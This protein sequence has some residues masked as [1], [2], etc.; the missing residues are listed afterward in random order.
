MAYKEMLNKIKGDGWYNY[1][2]EAINM[3]A[4]HDSEHG[5]LDII[6]YD[7]A[8]EIAKRELE[9]GGLLRLAY[10]IGQ[11]EILNDEYY[12]LDGYGNLVNIK[13]DWVEMALEE[14]IENEEK[15]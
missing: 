9:R 14:I 6:S 2:D 8:E 4:E 5:G 12:R 11:A 3:L 10:F 13:K 7:V 15:Y 1:M